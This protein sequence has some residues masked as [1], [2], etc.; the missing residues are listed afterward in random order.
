MNSE[1]TTVNLVVGFLGL[2]VLFG[3]GIG[4]Y[5]AVFDKGVPDFIIATTSG[6]IGALASLLAKTSTGAQEVVVN[7]AN[8]DPVPVADVPAKPARR[9]RTTK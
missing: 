1:R 4:G 5:L 9:T 7:N 3:M 6:A 2:V 8:T